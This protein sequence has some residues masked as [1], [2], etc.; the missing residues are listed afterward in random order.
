VEHLLLHQSGVTSIDDPAAAAKCLS[1]EELLEMLRQSKPMFEPGKRVQYSNEGYFLLAMIAE[2]VTGETYA[3]FHTEA[4]A[5][6]LRMGHTG[7]A[8]QDPPGKAFAGMVP[9]V[10]PGTLQQSPY[11][12]ALP[13]G[14]GSIY[15]DARDLLSWLRASDTNPS[16]EL[17]KLR[18]PYGW[19]KRNYT[20]HPLIEQS[21][22]IQGFTAYMSF[23]P[24]AHLYTVLLSRVES[25]FLNRIPKDME[26][27]LF[28]GEASRPPELSAVPVDAGSLAAYAGHFKAESIPVPQ[29]FE[30]E[31]GNLLMT[32]GNLFPR[33]LT[34]IGPDSFYMRQEYAKVRFERDATGKPVRAIWQ[35]EAGDP[36]AM[37]RESDR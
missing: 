14:A 1:N 33:Y 31:G 20:G 27:V 7:S 18:Y 24:G 4:I 37:V 30:A 25:G 35:W 17:T 29:V 2:R 9:G 16:F 34:P 23:Y 10:M 19:G 36:I 28:G 8:C 3:K 15:T 22:S 13:P 26:S 11:N 12:Q 6:P 5:G 32:W 21:G